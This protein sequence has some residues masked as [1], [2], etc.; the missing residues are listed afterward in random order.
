MRLDAHG[1]A[2]IAPEGWE[3][4][5][6]RA[7][8]TVAGEVAPPV[9]HA[10][11]FPLPEERGDFG[12]GAVEIMAS[13]DVFVSLLEYEARQAGTALFRRRAM[14][15]RIDPD[16]FA[17]NQLQRWLPGQAGLQAFF[18]E[19]ERPF[20]LYIVIGSFLNRIALAERAERLLATVRIESALP[21]GVA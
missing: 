11:T 18:T 19:G 4:R 16:R 14:P 5:I 15:R 17:T 2:V 6:S 3:V 21:P 13:D 7:D 9:L 10:A 8:E 12:S 1:L 20:C